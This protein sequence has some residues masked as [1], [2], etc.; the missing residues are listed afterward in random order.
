MK[1]IKVLIVDD[2][3]FFREFIATSIAR[4][5]AIEVVGKAADPYQARDL[6]VNLIPDVM[7]LDVEMPRMNGIEFLRKLMPQYPLPV[8][9]V[10]S[11]SNAVFDALDAGAVD[12]VNKSNISE[13][14]SQR[15]FISELIVKIKIASIA[16]VGQHKH[17]SVR[18]EMERGVINHNKKNHIIAIGASTGGTEA[19]YAIL[20]EL[21]NDLP[22]IV[23]VQHMPSVFTRL[24]AERLNNTCMMEV[25]EAADGD[26]VLPG[27]VLIAPGD[28]QMEVVKSGG[29]YKVKCFKGEKVNGHCPSV[30]VLFDS[31]SK[32][33]GKNALGII[34]TGMGNDGAQGLLNMREKGAETLGQN[35]ESCVVYGMP[36]AAKKIGAVHAEHYLTEIPPKI[37]Q[38]NSS[39]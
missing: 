20:K 28:F 30:D 23:I 14:N 11:A 26:E 32:V 18:W 12:F 38:W 19:T 7:L 9:V 31:V 37:Y 15:Y 4:D 1:K 35:Q 22:G 5:P 34:L 10:S 27:R 16:K 8:L 17:N 36:M 6:I 2:S 25:K 13:E 29:G 3:M 24:Y 21:G 39:K 33:C